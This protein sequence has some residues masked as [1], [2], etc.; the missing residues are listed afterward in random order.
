MGSK[1]LSNKAK[2]ELILAVFNSKKSLNTIIE[3][4]SADYDMNEA[5]KEE[6]N[7]IDEDIIALMLSSLA[8]VNKIKGDAKSKAVKDAKKILKSKL[9]S[10]DLD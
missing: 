10:L 3:E 8:L 7:S 4:Y 5:I 9:A 2:I 1:K 6:L